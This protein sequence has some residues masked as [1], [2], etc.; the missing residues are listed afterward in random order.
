MT[1]FLCAS[2]DETLN[3]SNDFTFYSWAQTIISKHSA[4][5]EETERDTLGTRSLY[6]QPVD[7]EQ[8]GTGGGGLLP[9]AGE[10][11]KG[12]RAT[13]S[14]NIAMFFLKSARC[15]FFYL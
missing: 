1:C 3:Y 14:E 12:P 5:C 9:P 10:E 13:R 15:K 11:N 2:A 8:K 7:W 6:D 4:V